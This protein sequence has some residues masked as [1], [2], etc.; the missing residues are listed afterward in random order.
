MKIEIIIGLHENF[1]TFH[2]M[3]GNIA[4]KGLANCLPHFAISSRAGVTLTPI[5]C[6]RITHDLVVHLQDDVHA[7]IWTEFQL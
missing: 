3:K 7:T 2:N 1:I 4:S 5:Y 6:F